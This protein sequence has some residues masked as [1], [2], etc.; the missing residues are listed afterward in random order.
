MP[1][2]LLA[3]LKRLTCLSALIM[4]LLFWGP[5]GQAVA[6]AQ[7]LATGEEETVLE[8]LPDP[9]TK[10]AVR[11]M[12]SR[13]SDAE[14]R[15][16]LLTRL[17]AVADAN[18]AAEGGGGFFDFLLTSLIGAGVSVKLAFDSAPLIP[19]A[20][21]K[22][23][24]TF[25]ERRGTEGTVIWFAVLA[26]AIAVGQGLQIF[27]ARFFAPWWDRV[28]PGQQATLTASLTVLFRRI[29][30]DFGGILVFALG[31]ATVLHTIMPREPIF[32]R[33]AAI[34]FIGAFIIFPKVM[35]AVAH[36]LNA[37]NRPHLRLI[38]T[39]DATAQFLTRWLVILAVLRGSMEFVLPFL[40]S[41]GTPMGEI[42]LG[43]WLNTAFYLTFLW[44]TWHAREGLKL[45]VLGKDTEPTRFELAISR[46][47]PV[48]CIS[49]I[50]INWAIIQMIAGAGRF[51]LLDWRREVTLF[52]LLFLPAFDTALRGLVKHMAPPMTGEG[53][54]AEK[55]H[56]DSKAAYLRIGRVLILAAIVWVTARIWGFNVTDLAAAGVGIQ[57]AAG[58]LRL[59]AI[60]GTGYLIWE[61]VTLW[62][63]IKLAKE[64]TAAGI[65]LEDA[66][67]AADAGGEG[68]GAGG[69]RLATVLPLVRWSAQTAIAVM[70]VLIALGHIGIDITPL[71]AGA[72]IVGLA[73][74]FGAQKLVADIVSGIFF[75]VD[76]AFRTGE[77]LEIGETRGTVES[78]SIRSL[79]LRH[80]K[81]AVHT[82]PF[83]EI[84]KI[85]NYSRDWVIMK[86]RFTV[87][88][89]TD[90]NKVKKIFKK[91]G[92]EMMEVPEFAE[93]FMQ[94]FKSQGVLEV[95]DVGMVVRG[96]FMAKPG[97][98][99]TLR[100]EIYNRVQ[101]AFDENGIQFARKEVRVRLEGEDRD[102][103]DSTEKAKLAGAAAAQEL[104]Q[105]APKPA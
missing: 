24:N 53:A 43:Y 4:G 74:G 21:M 34:S 3:S 84:P 90:L 73:I 86:L 102:D 101:K 37:P 57:A 85:T 72:G 79:Q 27:M 63:N 16:L 81:G 9:L 59:F 62:I 45:M 19:D 8:T 36:F 89:D 97:K 10:E 22:G 94:P 35:G 30:L 82:L 95:D 38:N 92:A 78:I 11:E 104:D 83:G 41:H 103:L 44:A 76:D 96:K 69:S 65:D 31:A 60:L 46:A 18:A 23:L 67:N 51:D 17:D 58:F 25:Y 47:Y 105:T 71:L 77:Y 100:K 14:V 40:A 26:L 55:A 54:L 80:H 42:R 75:L 39:D 98:Q 88:F 91:I 29:I 93:D 13:L 28:T 1:K 61:L 48:F 33:E 70:T 99:F 6:D 7:M 49:L 87:P 32:N 52:L 64:M 50:L 15:A 5:L 20:V 66:A 12:V 56:A 2:Y 68:G